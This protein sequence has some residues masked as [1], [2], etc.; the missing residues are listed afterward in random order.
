M[1]QRAVAIAAWAKR[2]C[3]MGPYTMSL[4]RRRADPSTRNDLSDPRF[5][6]G[7]AVLKL[8]ADREHFTVTVALLRVARA[9]GIRVFSRNPA[10]L[11]RSSLV[12]GIGGAVR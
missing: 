2:L 5:T 4:R 12:A 7:D 6:I 9:S 10:P 3:V 1:G 11:R 8:R